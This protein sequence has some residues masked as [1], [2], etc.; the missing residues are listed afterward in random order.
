MVFYTQLKSFLNGLGFC[1]LHR[2]KTALNLGTSC[3]LERSRVRVEATEFSVLVENVLSTNVMI[4][5]GVPQ[6]SILRPLFF[7]IYLFLSPWGR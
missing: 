4:T 7:S 6:I 2:T 5:C 3:W 1:K